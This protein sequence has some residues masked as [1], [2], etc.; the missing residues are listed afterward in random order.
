[1]KTKEPKYTKEDLKQMQAFPL[2]RKIAIAQTRIFEWILKN[3][4]DHVAVSFSGGKDSTVLLDLVRR[5]NPNVIAIFSDTGLEFPEIREFALSH[6]KVVTVRPKN[7]FLWVLRHCGY[8]LISK[9]VATQIEA[10]RNNTE[11][12]SQAS[13]NKLLGTGTFVGKDGIR[14][15]SWFNMDKWLPLLQLPIPI[16]VKCCG[17]IKETP[18]AKYQKEHG[19]LPIIGTMASESR[20]REKGWLN[21][22]CNAFDLASPRSMPLAIWTEQ[23]IFNYIR[24]FDIPI[25]SVYGEI[26]P[27]TNA[28]VKSKNGVCLKCTG[29][30]RTGCIFC[31]YGA[32]ME[33]RELGETR[34]QLLAK[35]HPQ[36]YDYCMRGGEWIDNPAYDPATPVYDK[37]NPAWTN[38]NPK[39]IWVANS[40]GLGYRVMLDMVNS[41]YGRDFIPYD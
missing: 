8:P 23:D 34:F 20:R 5:I 3:G 28:G 37:I 11:K 10:A 2:E 14:R 27:T 29:R 6:D 16:S 21:N 35:T 4:E 26:V 32:H 40:K 17:F 36:R 18:I 33:K 22:G 19:L 7:N 41:V 31:A 39:K 9:D 25:C 24:R 12:R 30:Q 13:I 38:W 1:M 15:E